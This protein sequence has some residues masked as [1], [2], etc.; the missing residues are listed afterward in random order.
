MGGGIP[1]FKIFGITIRLHYSWFIIFALITW[2][3]VS[4]FPDDN[5][6]TAARIGISLVA[7]I[8]LFG[9]LIAHEVMHSVVAQK[10]GIPVH[11][12]TLFIFG[13]VSQITKEPEK[14]GD[15]VRIALAGPL[16]S[17][18]CGGIFFGIWFMTQNAP[19]MVHDVILWLGETNIIL[20]VFNLI[21][22]FP[23]DGGRVLRGILWRQ[24]RNMR[25]ATK[26]AANIGRGVG[27]VFIIGG[28]FLIFSG[29]VFQG[30]W[31]AFIGW[32]LENAAASSYR[33]VALN[34]IMQGHT[35]GEVLTRDCTIVP[36]DITVQQL[37]NEQI[38]TGG[39]R[40]FPVAADNKALGLI[41]LNDVRA[42]PRNLWDTKMVSDAMIPAEKM[43][44][45]GPNEDLVKVFQLLTEKDINQVP[46]VEDGKI[47]GM[48]GRD[49][50]L[51]FVRVRTDL[52]M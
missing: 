38:L 32:F 1:V 27:Y 20:A 30:F 29:V 10:S 16:T 45:V 34:E 12:I 42:I 40:C 3:L 41:T 7:S 43:V 18:V 33:Q 25:D 21:P 11:S 5:L 28:I 19:S 51:A 14:P 37:V 35:A 44:A 9:S 49:A 6:S 50:L 23:L 17:L 36:P 8:L 2:Q 46:V 15:E 39:R 48:I 13:G 22:G 24:R 4:N 47:V 31:I 52:G 26:V